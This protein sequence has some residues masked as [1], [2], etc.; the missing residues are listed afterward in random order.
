MKKAIFF[1]LDGT[2]WDAISPIKDSYNLTFKKMNINHKFSYEEVKS[3][4]GLTPLETVKLIFK[5]EISDK[6]GLDI[7]KKMVQEEIIYLKDRPG[8]LYEDEES[9]LS[10]L[11]KKYPLYIISNSDKGY[12]ENYLNYFHFNTYFKGHL[13]AGDT[14]LDKYENILKVKN[15]NNFDNVIYVGD[16][17]KD[18]LESKKA[19]VDFI[20]ASYGF[21]KIEEKV[22]SINSIKD[23]EK[24]INKIFN[25]DKI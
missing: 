1:D 23:L 14:L 8:V 2:L 25:S 18:Y 20:H 6:E 5:D 22:N 21:G 19:G 24:E 3:F 4:M 9:V 10:S 11:S 17:N 16:T 15:E 12:I 13:C 7:F